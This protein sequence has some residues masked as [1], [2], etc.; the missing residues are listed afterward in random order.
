M[1]NNQ[2]R[3]GPN[4][5]Q[6]SDVAPPIMTAPTLSYV[7][8]TEFVELPS[9]G[10][11]YPKDHPLHGEE[12]IEIRFMTA[13]EEDILSSAVLIKKGLAIERLL[14][15][16]IVNK[17]IDA[18][19][20]LVGDRSAIMIAARISSY[21]SSYDTIVACSACGQQSDLMFDL[22]NSKLTGECFN[23]KYLNESQIKLDDNGLFLVDLP[24]SQVQVC[25]RMSTVYDE[26]NIAAS[27]QESDKE[28][29]SLVTD[30]LNTLIASVDGHFERHIVSNFI[31]NMPAADSRYIRKIYTEL[32][33]DVSIKQ[34][35]FCLECGSREEREVVLSADF[36]WPR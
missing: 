28:V 8:P 1:R 2:K 15:N 9:R 3:L 6:A 23:D 14:E 11:L 25:L 17:D 18:K 20:L 24:R 21:G 31:E 32:V 34:D 22:S 4:G 29:D 30:V 26:Q 35:F 5:P 27:G 13:K 36:F 19:S 33:P 7:V 16:L 10:R 12:A